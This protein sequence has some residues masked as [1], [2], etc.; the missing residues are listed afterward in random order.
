MEKTV[1]PH[2]AYY[3]AGYIYYHRPDQDDNV[4]AGILINGIVGL[5][6]SWLMEVEEHRT[7]AVGDTL[8]ALDENIS[9]RGVFNG[10]I[11]LMLRHDRSTVGSVRS[12]I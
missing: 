2:Q 11:H 5:L 10:I 9:V 6:K 3:L 4:H 1:E 7:E 12:V 8:I